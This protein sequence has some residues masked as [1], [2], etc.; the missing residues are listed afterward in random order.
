MNTSTQSQAIT[1]LPPGELDAAKSYAPADNE[2][3]NL[4]ALLNDAD[5]KVFLNRIADFAA[6]QANSPRQ[7]D[8]RRKTIRLRKMLLGE[9][10]G[11]YDKTRG[12]TNAKTEGDGI[13]FDSTIP[14]TIKTLVAQ[15]VKTKPKLKCETRTPDLIDK[16]EAARLAEK[17]LDMDADN[18]FTPKR[19]QR[20]WTWNLLAAGDS[21]RISY[22]N[23]QKDG[24]GVHEEVYEPMEIAGGDEANFCALCGSTT[25][26]DDNNCAQ[27]GNPQVDSYKA[28]SSQITVK[29][30]TAYKQIGDADYDVPDALE[31]TVIG[32]TDDIAGALIVRRE[33]TIPR[34]VLMDALDVDSIP[35]TDSPATLNYKQIFY[36]SDFKD[37]TM[38]EFRPAHYEELWVA[39]AV[40]AAYK[41]PKD[42]TTQ[43]GD[44]F[45]AG[46]KISE[47]FPNGLFFS[48]IKETIYTLYPQAATECVSHA[49]NAISEDFHGQ[50][51]WDLIELGDQLT[52]A[53]SMKMNSLLMDSTSPLMIREGFVD[54][55]NFENKFGLIVPISQDAKEVPL[56][57]LMARVP[58]AGMPEQAY[59]LGEA[60]KGEI[61][62]SAGSFSTQSDA[63]DIRAMGTATGIAAISEQTLGRR[64]PAMQL[65]SQMLVDQAYQILEMRQK[66][67]CQKMYASAAKDLGDNA[68]KWFMDCNIRQDIVISVIPESWMPQSDAQKQQGIRDF[69]QIAGQIVASIGDQDML[70][71][72][73]RKANETLGANIDFDDLLS[74]SVE[75]Q[76]RIDALCDVASFIEKAFPNDIFDQ[77]G[78]IDPNAIVLAYVHT[79]EMLKIVHEPSDEDDIFAKLPLDVMFDEHSEFEEAYTDWLRSS[80]GHAASDFTRTLI[81][82]LASYHMQAEAYRLLKINEYSK[83]PQKADLE[84]ELAANQAMSDQAKANMPPPPPPPVEIPE[85]PPH[86]LQKVTESINYKDVPS[87]VKR[88]IEMQAGLRPATSDEHD[89]ETEAAENEAAPPPKPV[90]ARPSASK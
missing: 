14:T 74:E 71:D 42:T 13:Y 89:T 54:T 20:E 3:S 79:A 51:E 75:A 5:F 57:D 84:A 56:G 66:Y 31:M 28:V 53:K 10:Y 1:A 64:G 7:W 6:S 81:R 27:C 59:E 55:E 23:Q 69:L 26:S 17:L 83:I 9:Y 86:P 35:E 4:K 48:R 49:C 39:P 38:E 45:K 52:E 77:T 61:Q 76:Q 87:S 68:I 63:P 58:S 21:F 82:E 70:K 36:H 67:W 73:L 32:D 12:W 43:G 30:G 25:L 72:I 47:M 85:M 41:L 44:T 34:C 60:L 29:K 78:G 62:Q 37:S 22:F 8:R 11:I 19:Q 46:T 33:R 50:G 90:T 18:D 65:Y 15:L 80:D 2:T 40:Y 88:Q 16:R 24:K